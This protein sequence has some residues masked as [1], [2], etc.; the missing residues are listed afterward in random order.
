L[1]AFLFPGCR[2]SRD[3]HHYRNSLFDPDIDPN[4]DLKESGRIDLLF[5]DGLRVG[6][7]VG[8]AFSREK[9]AQ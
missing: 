2:Q 7:H 6:I 9:V 4:P 8:A 1:P 3:R 5:T